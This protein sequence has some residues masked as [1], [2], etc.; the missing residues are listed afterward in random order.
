MS[1]Q[2]FVGEAGPQSF[3]LV[4]KYAKHQNPESSA[5]KGQFQNL[6][7]WSFQEMSNPLKDHQ[8]EV[9]FS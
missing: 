2:C 3:L 7:V 9:H 4:K 8:N 6:S 5:M 1:F